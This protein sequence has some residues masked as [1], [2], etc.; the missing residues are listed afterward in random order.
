MREW[1][2]A[3]PEHIP[4]FILVETKQGAPKDVKL[5][6]PEP[7]TTVTFDALDAEIRSVFTAS[8][9]IT[10]DDVSR[11]VWD[12]QSSGTCRQLAKSRQRTGKVIFLMDQRSVGPMYLANHPSLRGRAIFTNAAPGQPDAAF[13]EL[14]D[15]PAAEITALVRK[16]Y[17]VRARTDADTK[18]ARVNDTTTRD[19]MMASG[20][21]ILSTDY[22]ANEPARWEGHYVV[23][24]PGHV[25][26]RCNP[27]NAPA[28]CRSAVAEIDGK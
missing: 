14:N 4:I 17:L 13:T 7:F 27:V 10:P 1:S 23:A 19:T 9:M 22:P 2:H 6:Q 11:F 21:Q 25:T 3:H 24:L 28:D 15:G 12:A 18:Q 8:E 26:A 5:T 16:G 20:A